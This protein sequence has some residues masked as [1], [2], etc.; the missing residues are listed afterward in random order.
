LHIQA[1]INPITRVLT[2]ENHPLSVLTRG[3]ILRSFTTRSFKLW[4]ITRL[5]VSF[6]LVLGGNNPLN[7]SLFTITAIV[8]L[9][10]VL[11]II[12]VRRHR[13]NTILASIGISPAYLSA[14]LWMPPAIGE[15]G[16]LA[17]GSFL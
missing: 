7:L 2:L 13:E 3:L 12:E 5:A 6:V 17:I 11:G 15:L 8:A 16:L 14:M 9:S 4:A 10:T 1:G